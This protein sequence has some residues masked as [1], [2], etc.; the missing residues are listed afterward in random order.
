MTIAVNSATLDKLDVMLNKLILCARV[1][2]MNICLCVKDSLIILVW[3]HTLKQV[4][5]NM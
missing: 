3:K 4:F 1:R 5:F 2:V